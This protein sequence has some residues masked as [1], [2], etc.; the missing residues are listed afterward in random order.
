MKSDGSIKVN[1]LTGF[2]TINGMNSKLKSNDINISGYLIDGKFTKLEKT[3]EVEN[4]YVEDKRIINIKTNTLNMY[5]LKA[6]YDKK[7]RI[8]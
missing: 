2:F 6:N 4:L 8:I 5:A 1:N 7:N 3:N